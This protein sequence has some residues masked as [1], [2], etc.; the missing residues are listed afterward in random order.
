[1]KS[2]LFFCVIMKRRVVITGIGVVSPVG[3]SAETFWENISNGKSGID[4]VTHFDTTNFP[5]KIGGEVKNFNPEDFISKKDLRRMDRFCHFA[6][7]AAR[8]AVSNSGLKISSEPERV[9]V[10]IGCGIGGFSVIEKQHEILMEKGPSRVSPFTIPMIIPDIAAGYV[11]ITFGA[12]GPNLCPVSACASAANAIGDSFRI[13]ARGD[14]DAVIAGGTE[15][16]ITPLSYA[17]FC[18]AR[19]M[20]KYNE[21]PVR[22]S[23]PFDLNRDG[24]VMGEGSGILIMEEL[25]HA[26]ARDA[27]ILAEV[28]GYGMTGDAYHITSPDPDG[29]GIENSMLLAL[30]DAGLNPAEVDYINAHGT[31]TEANDKIESAAIKKVFKEKRD[32]LVSSTKSMTGHLLGASGGIEAAACILALRNNLVPPTINY[33]T[34]DPECNLDYVPNQ[35]RKKE[36][37]YVMSNNLGFGGHN[38]SLVFSKYDV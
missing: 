28:L 26:L 36:L 25:N 3:N 13:I 7:A 19:A 33:E 16:A 21:V 12:K 38:V 20:S 17:G 9:G 27:V 34:P 1:M 6:I 23:R 10:V 18:A 29:K 8:Q 30:K 24:F 35:A 5:T 11:A 31:S 37:H 32:I 15:S 22:A 14:A 2:D 4:Y